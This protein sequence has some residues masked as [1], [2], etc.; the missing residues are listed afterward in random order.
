MRE[1]GREESGDSGR[2]KGRRTGDIR[3]RKRKRVRLEIGV[4]EMKERNES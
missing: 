3:E 1:K 4:A 2:Q